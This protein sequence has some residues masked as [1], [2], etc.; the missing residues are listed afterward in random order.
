MRESSQAIGWGFLDAIFTFPG[1]PH[2]KAKRSLELFA[3][4]VLPQL[5]NGAPAS[6]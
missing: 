6:P 1:L 4:E 3:T 2:A 5:R